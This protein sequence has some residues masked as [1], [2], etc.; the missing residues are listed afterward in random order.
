[1]HTPGNPGVLVLSPGQ[2]RAPNIPKD[3]LGWVKNL[4]FVFCSPPR[5]GKKKLFNSQLR[6]TALN[7]LEGK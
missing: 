3:G 6:S 5:G 4:K 2:K 1:M 7:K